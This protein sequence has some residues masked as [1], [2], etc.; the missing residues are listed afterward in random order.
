MGK[1]DFKVQ[2][3]RGSMVSSFERSLEKLREILGGGASDEHGSSA[4]SLESLKILCTTVFKLHSIEIDSWPSSDALQAQARDNIGQA[5][6]I[7]YKHV[8]AVGRQGEALGDYSKFLLIAIVQLQLST[9]GLK[10]ATEQFDSLLKKAILR[11]VFHENEGGKEEIESAAKVSSEVSELVELYE[12]RVVTWF[13]RLC[14]GNEDSGREEQTQVLKVVVD[15]V[16]KEAGDPRPQRE[17][18]VIRLLNLSLAMVEKLAGEEE[19]V[20]LFRRLGVLAL[21]ILGDAKKTNEN[22]SVAMKQYALNVVVP[23]LVEYG[24]FANPM[25]H[26]SISLFDFW[27]MIRRKVLDAKVWILLFPAVCCLLYGCISLGGLPVVCCWFWVCGKGGCEF[28]GLCRDVRMTI[29]L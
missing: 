5:L 10:D 23:R 9:S 8:D 16:E 6:S 21:S 3:V 25:Y 2:A 28:V 7:C 12:S 26:E 20:E 24:M 15:V 14:C 29:T 11:L 22:V 19:S 4:S 27:D 18:G 1:V 17:V 13:D